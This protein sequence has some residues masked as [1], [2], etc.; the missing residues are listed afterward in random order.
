[1]NAPRPESTHEEAVPRGGRIIWLVAVVVGAAGGLLFLGE[2]ISTPSA[3][4]KDT[5]VGIGWASLASGPG[6]MG[7]LAGIFRPRKAVRTSL[8]LS[9]V[10]MLIFAPI[11]GEGAICLIYIAPWFLVVA[12]VSALVTSAIGR[13]RKKTRQPLAAI[14]LLLLPSGSLWLEEHFPTRAEPVTLSNSVLIAAPVEQVWA[15][16]ATVDLSVARP[17]P[18]LVRALLPQ[19]LAVVGGG[20]HVGAE[21]RV[22]FHNGVVVARVIRSEPPLRFEMDLAVTE[23]GR[24]FFDHWARL[25][26]SAFVLEPLPDGR[27]RL[28]HATS[29]E[30]RV[31]VRWYSD[32]IERRLGHLLQGYALQAF[33]EQ[34][35]TERTPSSPVA[36]R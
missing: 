23:S 14:F 9:A 15:E 7:V 36:V 18:V 30:P 20:A 26:R 4:A 2:R 28:T 13:W 17:A 32:P 27:T 22:I 16:L 35:F 31:S 11:A 25:G 24:E 3:G 8:L 6:I 19:P 33:A 29:Y 12:P 34:L 21:R 1:M 5:L 10:S